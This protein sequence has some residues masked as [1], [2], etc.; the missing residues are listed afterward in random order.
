MAD[1]DP[2][3]NPDRLAEII[4]AASGNGID[5]EHIPWSEVEE[6]AQKLANT[7][8]AKDSGIRAA[9]G[10]SALPKSIATL[11]GTAYGHTIPA[12]P[13]K[14]ATFEMLRVQQFLDAGLLEILVS[15][16][17]MHKQLDSP[18]TEDLKVAKT[19]VGAM[20]NACLGFEPAKLYLRKLGA[21]GAVIAL[22][23]SLYPPG[24]WSLAPE[25]S[26]PLDLLSNSY[27][28]RTGLADWSWRVVSAINEGAEGTLI[29]LKTLNSLA[30]SLS[31]FVPTRPSES[32]LINDVESRNA[33]IEADIETLEECV[34]LLES[35]S[36]DSEEV[37]L[38]FAESADAD[39][40]LGSVLDFIEFATYPQYWSLDGEEEQKRREK[41]FDIC[42]AG[43]IKALVSIA[44]EQKA[45]ESLWNAYSEALLR[46]PFSL[47]PQLI[48]FLR[49]DEDIK[50]KHSVTGLLKNLAQAPANRKPLGETGVLEQL[51]RSGIW[52]KECDMA[53]TVQVSAIGIAKHLC[54]GDANNTLHLMSG[55]PSN[56]V[57]Q[58]QALVKRSDSVIVKSEG[59]R[60][61][62]Y[63]VK[64]L[65]K[66]DPPSTPQTTASGRATPSQDAALQRREAALAL[67]RT[68][69]VRALVDLLVNGQK[70]T[71]LLNESSF[72]LT[73]IA[74]KLEG[75]VIIA[76]EIFTPVQAL[77]KAPQSAALQLSDEP[78]TF[79]TSENG[80]TV[81]KTIV[82]NES[83]K[84]PP[85]LRANACS[86]IG[87]LLRNLSSESS[88]SLKEQIIGE[89]KDV[90]AAIPQEK[91]S[92]EKLTHAARW[93]M[94]GL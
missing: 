23:L 42:K 28:I 18:T 26:E 63:C 94:D 91:D 74:S 44:G 57:D 52:E 65:W 1:S 19:A 79:Q 41:S 7:L 20:L 27:Q 45:M 54:N 16:I 32:P 89:F 76:T 5:K 46:E 90:L 37:R 21:P 84:H 40:L 11:L 48:K 92:P 6:A 12:L 66:K 86:L 67:S 80:A 31:N 9:L 47:A 50:V 70:H 62:A 58:I 25:T 73:L 39:A 35:L 61:L 71:I 38:A 34:T 83:G 43:V 17:E 77:A 15:L 22:S 30:L 69:I 2:A 36:L 13:L 8:R 78:Q 75:A 53:E 10:Q 85:E 24:V 51:A 4:V 81:L 64:S 72:A 93:A 55:T 60:V 87:T 82:S 49:Q 3:G 14:L 68:P 29:G 88:K 56:G 59:T 33:L